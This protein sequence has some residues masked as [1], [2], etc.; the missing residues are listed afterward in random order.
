M[1]KLAKPEIDVS[2][3]VPATLSDEILRT[4]HLK[5]N[6]TIPIKTPYDRV[7]QCR[8][9]E[10]YIKASERVDLER[11]VKRY[12][13]KSFD[14]ESR[15]TELRAARVGNFI[16]LRRQHEATLGRSK[17]IRAGAA[18]SGG[19]RPAA[20]DIAVVKVRVSRGDLAGTPPEYGLH[21]KLRNS[22]R[23]HGVA[24]AIWTLLMQPGAPADLQGSSRA[25]SCTARLPHFH[26]WDDVAGW[27]AGFLGNIPFP[28][29]WHFGVASFSPHFIHIGS[30]D[31]V[32]K[33]HP[34]LSTQLNSVL[35]HPSF[36]YERRPPV[37][38]S[39]GAPP[40]WG[41]GG[42]GFESRARHE[43][44]KLGYKLVYK[45]YPA[46]P[47]GITPGDQWIHEDIHT[48]STGLGLTRSTT[49]REHRR[50]E[51]QTRK[52]PMSTWYIVLAIVGTHV[53]PHVGTPVYPRLTTR[54]LEEVH[55][56]S[57]RPQCV[58][59]LTAQHR[60]RMDENALR[61]IMSTRYMILAGVGTP[62][63]PL[64]TSR[65]LAEM[66]IL[67]Q[68]PQCVLPLTAQHRLRMDEVDYQ[69]RV[70][71]HRA[72]C[73]E[74]S[75]V[76][77]VHD[78]GQFW[79]YCI[80]TVNFP[81][82]CGDGY[83][84][85]APITCVAMNFVPAVAP[86]GGGVRPEQ[87]EMP[88]T[89]DMWCLK[90]NIGRLP[91]SMSD[92][93]AACIA[94]N[95]GEL[96]ADNKVRQV[97]RIVST[98][99][100]PR[101]LYETWYL[102]AASS[103][104]SVFRISRHGAK[105][106]PF[107]ATRLA[108][109][110]LV[111]G[112]EYS[113]VGSNPENWMLTKSGDKVWY[114]SSE[115]IA[116]I[117]NSIR[118]L[119]GQRIKEYATLSEDCEALR[120]AWTPPLQFA[121]VNDFGTERGGA[122]ASAERE[123]GGGKTALTGSYG[124]SIY[125]KL[126]RRH[127]APYTRRRDARLKK[128]ARGCVCKRGCLSQGRRASELRVH[129]VEVSRSTLVS[130]ERH[131]LIE[132]SG[133]CKTQTELDDERHR[134]CHITPSSKVH[135]AWNIM[136]FLHFKK[137]VLNVS[138][139]FSDIMT[140]SGA[141][142]TKM[143]RAKTHAEISQTSEAEQ[144]EKGSD[145]SEK[146]RNQME[147]DMTD[148]FS[149]EYQSG[150]KRRSDKKNGLQFIYTLVATP[151]VPC[152]RQPPLPEPHRGTAKITLEYLPQTHLHTEG[153]LVHA[154]HVTAFSG[155]DFSYRRGAVERTRMAGWDR[156][157]AFTSPSQK[158]GGV[159]RSGRERGKAFLFF[160]RKKYGDTASLLLFK[161]ATQAY[162]VQVHNFSI[163]EAKELLQGRAR[164]FS[165]SEQ[166][167]G[168]ITAWVCL[169]T[170]NRSA[171]YSLLHQEYGGDCVPDNVISWN[172]ASVICYLSYCTFESRLTSNVVRS[173]PDLNPLDYYIWG[174]LK[175]VDQDFPADTLHAVPGVFERAR[176]N[177]AA[178][179][180]MPAS[181]PRVENVELSTALLSTRADNRSVQGCP[182]QLTRA[183]THR[184]TQAK[185]QKKSRTSNIKRKAVLCWN[186]ELQLRNSSAPSTQFSSTDRCRNR[187][188]RIV[189]LLETGWTIRRNDRYLKRFAV[190]VSLHWTQ[191]EQEGTRACREG[192]GRPRIAGDKRLPVTNHVL[193]G[194]R[195]PPQSRL[196]T[197]WSVP[198]DPRFIV[199][200]RITPAI[201]ILRPLAHRE[202]LAP[203]WTAILVTTKAILVGQLHQLWQDLPQ[204]DIR[205]LYASM[206]DCIATC[207]RGAG[208]GNYFWSLFV[209]IS[210]VFNLPSVTLSTAIRFSYSYTLCP[211]TVRFMKSWHLLAVIL[212]IADCTSTRNLR[213]VSSRAT[214][215]ERTCR[216]HQPDRRTTLSYDTNRMHKRALTAA[217]G[218]NDLDVATGCL[219]Y[220]VHGASHL[221]G[222]I[223]YI[224]KNYSCMTKNK[225]PRCGLHVGGGESRAISPEDLDKGEL[226]RFAWRDRT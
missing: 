90:D 222:G 128:E 226:P 195:R 97:L 2:S 36:M 3:V 211:D 217:R 149:D 41:A 52:D 9:R 167:P 29:P 75:H 152:G 144:K 59:P 131:Q 111:I 219:Q 14:G 192:L 114:C 1:S 142:L 163:L 178:C 80:P 157:P 30:Q 38:Q 100:P 18:V 11:S 106:F 84:I 139:F 117:Q 191:W 89:G 79:D 49:N 51:L 22:S 189:G 214:R 185:F 34:N 4:Q 101:P 103:S 88:Q 69:S 133:V 70:S 44:F 118:P 153:S 225:R 102:N 85:P 145:R 182:K 148:G 104:S 28:P 164:N 109:R 205:R 158:G 87:C 188:R 35:I 209:E 202:R 57:Q 126:F 62:V 45:P 175:R 151:G 129:D 161:T 116:Y 134:R 172:G 181:L 25:G 122:N 31:P 150:Y 113:R 169:T 46:K 177:D 147:D 130:V 77:L 66:D 95:T 47:S 146:H 58:L 212:Q 156:I 8:E 207:L 63:Y 6:P 136:S 137:E 60:L 165:I 56:L 33:S 203:E 135:G 74:G 171:G 200:R 40:V 208:G 17:L 162:T 110:Q 99:T 213:V 48:Q 221:P 67:S 13:V 10:I 140:A 76:N 155:R 94:E 15:S 50:I 159:I 91:D 82:T 194:Y 187:M 108:S 174:Y 143:F 107:Y 210:V 193:S 199:E 215:T 68:L 83:A 61:D 112:L 201:K 23:I 180:V 42:S 119:D 32:A 43:C 71:T 21:E 73:S 196:E 19:R 206:H 179:S 12:T 183:Q 72:P 16:V 166:Q 186:T 55:L 204:E 115:S 184:I 65:Q 37:V 54:K 81:T 78:T 141:V 220:T 224:Y 93:T 7:K 125:G 121:W 138:V 197:S 24:C 27:P 123:G 26:M 39:V 127:Y 154:Q 160:E 124:V 170:F 216:R 120:M 223:G 168:E 86:F 198:R 176:V 173:E 20:G 218:A 64:S 96:V 5:S 53:Y 92:R 132:F 105:L 98:T 190:T